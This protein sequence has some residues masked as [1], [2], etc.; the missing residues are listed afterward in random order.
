M[1]I[2]NKQQHVGKKKSTLN[3]WAFAGL[4][5][6][7]SMF[8]L[9]PAHAGVPPSSRINAISSPSITEGNAGTKI[10]TFVVTCDPCEYRVTA[11]VDWVIDDGTATTADNDYADTSGNFQV[12]G[13]QG[14]ENHE[15]NVTINGDIDI[16]P[17]ETL[18][19]RLTNASVGAPS[20]FMDVTE[21]TGTIENDDFELNVD[22]A[23]SSTESADPVTA[24]SGVGNLT[25]VLTASSNGPADASNVTV[26]STATFPVGATVVSVTPSGATT[27]SNTNPANWDIGT[28]ND[29]DSATLTYV[30][31]VAAN[32]AA[33]TDTIK[34]DANVSGLSET[35]TNADNDTTSQATSVVREVDLEV[36]KVCPPE[37]V[38]GSGANNY[39]C[40]ITVTN[41]GPSQA[42]GVSM[43]D[44]LAAITGVSDG[45]VISVSQG[46]PSLIAGSL[47]WDV[48]V[49]DPGQD[50]VLVFARTVSLQAAEGSPLISNTATVSGTETDSDD[51]N[52]NFTAD[53]NVRWPV[54]IFGVEKEYE[55]GGAGPVDVTL[56][57]TDSTGL[58]V[59]DP[60]T[61]ATPTVLS[62]SRFDIDPDGSGTSCTITEVVPD[63]FYEAS[64][65]DECDVDP[66][67]DLG[68]Y[69]C[70]I[71]NAVTRATFGVTKIFDD[72]N[73]VD[74][75]LVTID[76]NTGLILDQDKLLSD[77]ESVEFV[78]TSFD[79]GTLHC[80]ITEDGETGYSGEYNNISLDV[81]NDESCEY[82]EVAGDG[83]FECEITNTPD[84]VDVKVTKE[85]VFEGNSTLEVFTGYTLTLYCDAYI[86]GGYKLGGGNMVESPTGEV[87]SSCGLI[88]KFAGPQGIGGYAEWC[89]SYIREGAT[90]V[91]A[92]VIPEFPD[93]NCYWVET[94]QDPAIEVDQSDCQSLTISAGNGAACTITN[95]V[96]FEGIPTLSQYGKLLLIIMMLGVGFV[97]FR[98]FV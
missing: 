62:I 48:G 80:I 43:S 34:I 27:V 81:T 86:E 69:A 84:P 36:L 61:A 24:G 40:T 12:T 6:L 32:T 58:L 70:T 97:S 39:L 18:T 53:T 21:A 93:S 88:K 2:P 57:C 72:G 91:T 85:W 87:L 11:T 94:R 42:S 50:E 30:F 59:Y 64:R 79:E 47:D 16:E 5:L 98:R 76:C 19:L 29:G 65:T 17:D 78:V 83:A 54:A 10:M 73:D 51:T 90:T 96:F 37:V 60:Q 89:K 56:E 9:A 33:G 20:F 1:T 7:L 28:L 82:T 55:S 41:N 23:L 38:A 66:T 25:Y 52:D 35:D 4:S 74:E 95:T 45:A 8:V 26:S 92:K 63:G 71:T 14:V 44:T 13:G 22:V 31:T 15:V 46:T 3:Q 68:E 77:G 67:A 75:V 49:L